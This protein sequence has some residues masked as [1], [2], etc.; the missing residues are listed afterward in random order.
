MNV[1]RRSPSRSHLFYRAVADCVIDVAIYTVKPSNTLTIYQRSSAATALVKT[2][3][4]KQGSYLTP[5]QD[6]VE[7]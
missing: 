1:S 6:D 2:V 3:S 7:K 5:T 4:I